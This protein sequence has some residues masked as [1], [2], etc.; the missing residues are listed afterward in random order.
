M[1]DPV[2][3]DVPQGLI[4]FQDEL[5]KVQGFRDATPNIDRRLFFKKHCGQRMLKVSAVDNGVTAI[6]VFHVCQVCGY[7]KYQSSWRGVG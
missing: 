4:K 6:S 2:V 7:N 5:R 1:I 3:T